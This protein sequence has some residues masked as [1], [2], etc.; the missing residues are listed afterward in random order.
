MC[1]YLVVPTCCL[2]SW[3][4]A[5]WHQP[6]GSRERD[7]SN[8]GGRKPKG[9]KTCKKD[10]ETP[11]HKFDFELVGIA[12]DVVELFVGSHSLFLPFKPEHIS[13]VPEQ[14]R[15]TRRMPRAC[16]MRAATSSYGR[17]KRRVQDL[18]HTSSMTSVCGTHLSHVSSNVVQDKGLCAQRFARQQAIREA[19]G[20]GHMM[21]ANKRGSQH[22]KPRSLQGG[23]EVR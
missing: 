15:E 6:A 17:E 8:K 11:Y 12:G 3:A 13:G 5:C 14:V 9:P 19:A 18:Q 22:M 21:K 10:A 2:P 20:T 1:D 23:T 16:L 7:P 4:C